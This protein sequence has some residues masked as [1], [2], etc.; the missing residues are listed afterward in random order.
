VDLPGGALRDEEW[1]AAFLAF[2]LLGSAE[3]PAAF[4]DA[5]LAAYRAE[6]GQ[7]GLVD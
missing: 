1:T 3:R 5:D 4:E 6:P 7:C 2:V